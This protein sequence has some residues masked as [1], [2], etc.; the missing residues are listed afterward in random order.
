MIS[1]LGIRLIKLGEHICEE[2]QRFLSSRLEKPLSRLDSR[3][4]RML[5]KLTG[6]VFMLLVT[7]IVVIIVV[8]C[9]HVFYSFVSRRMGRDVEPIL[10][11]VMVLLLLALTLDRAQHALKQT[12]K[13]IGGTNV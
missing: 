11:A 6:P 12:N 3:R 1:K 9:V 5:N 7:L 8:I 10:E 2:A 4:K 13:E